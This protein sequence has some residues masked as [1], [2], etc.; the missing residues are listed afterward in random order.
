[1]LTVLTLA[2][3]AAAWVQ[4]GPSPAELWDAGQRV[5]AV[6]SL[7]RELS[8]RPVDLEH[9][10][11]LVEWELA[12]HRYEAALEHMRGLGPEVE[13]LRGLAL[14][15]SSRFE[16]ALEHLDS[17]QAGQLLMVIDALWAL[18]RIER[19]DRAIDDARRLIGEHDARVQTLLGRRHVRNGR[20]DEAVACFR[21]ALA[22]EPHDPASLFGLGQS[23]LRLD[24]REE[25]LRFLEQHR[26]I[27]P[28]LD[29]LD[30]CLRSLDLN[31]VS[32]HNHAAV[33][34]AERA[35]GHFERAEAAYRTA[36]RLADAE[37]IVPI[38]LRYARLLDEDLGNLPGALE[39]LRSAGRRVDDARVHVRAGDLLLASG[40][41]AAALAAFEQARELRPGDALIARRIEA[42]RTAMESR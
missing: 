1:M 28:L 4:S 13:A 14:F 16:E 38:A 36:A 9:R 10:R 25:G 8:A 7:E 35:L 27:T 5:E 42:A 40:Q 22:I 30:F 26:R 41:A 17:G 18:G 24:R 29:R 32:A 31:P 21:A 19:L 34:D 33:G 39:V 12:I 6:A 20:F 15:R 23:L 3:G 11:Q 37:E 2:V